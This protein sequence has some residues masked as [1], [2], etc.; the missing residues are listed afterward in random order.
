MKSKA[1]V[2]LLGCI[3]LMVTGCQ[4]NLDSNIPK[5]DEVVKSGTNSM[6][7]REQSLYFNCLATDGIAAYSL[8]QLLYEQPKIMESVMVDYT[9]YSEDYLTKTDI[10]KKKDNFAILPFELA[11]DTLL[12][13]DTYKLV[14]VV[15]NNGE[16]EYRLGLIITN[17]IIELHPEFVETFV[18]RYL[19][20]CTWVTQNP[21]RALAYAVQL[22]I[23][24]S[25]A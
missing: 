12:R 23:A 24:A 7:S 13:H 1:L 10:D 20:S 3:I 5:K 17:D 19:E 16:P 2:C 25:E 18:K 9:L 6:I 8:L 11:I 15:K 4:N 14:G 21:E 22:N